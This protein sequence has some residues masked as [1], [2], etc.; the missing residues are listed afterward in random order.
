MGR[1]SQTVFELTGGSADDVT[2]VSTNEY[3]AGKA[4]APRPAN[5]V[6]ELDKIK[7][8]GFV[9]RDAD[10]ALAAYLATA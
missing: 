4:A 9:P 10:I 2:G 5:S 8:A 1:C 7:A 3:F 6:L